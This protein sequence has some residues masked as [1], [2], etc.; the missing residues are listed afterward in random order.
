MKR[1]NLT[2]EEYYEKIATILTDW[3][4]YNNIQARVWVETFTLPQCIVNYNQLTWWDCAETLKHIMID[5]NR[6]YTGNNPDPF[7]NFNSY[8]LVG[9][10]PEDGILSRIVDK[11]SRIRWLISAE[12]T[13]WAVNW[14]SLADS[15]LDLWAYILI[16]TLYREW[17]KNIPQNEN[18][19]K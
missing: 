8:R 16:L 4:F 10:D 9:V 19:D 3:E 6:D 14:E 1:S 17:H 12:S 11:V 5:K 18:S 13:T 2:K 7:Y 15:W